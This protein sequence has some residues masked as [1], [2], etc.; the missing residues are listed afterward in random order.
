MDYYPDLQA[1]GTLGL[2]RARSCRPGSGALQDGQ[3][4]MAL[5]GLAT[6]PPPA[7]ATHA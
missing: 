4:D 6:S 1:P 3:L 7:I 5:V 2:R